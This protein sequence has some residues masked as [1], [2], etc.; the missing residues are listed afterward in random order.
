M[1]KDKIVWIT[2]ASAGIGREMALQFAAAGAHVVVSARRENRLQQVVKDIEA[3][4][5]QGLAIACDVT[6]EEAVKQA[7]EKVVHH[8]GRLD[9]TVANAGFSIL[10]PLEDLSMEDWQ[11]QFS[12]NVFGLCS[13]IRHSLPHLRKTRGRAVLMSSV[14]GLGSSP[15]AAAY[16]AS[17]AAVRAIGQTLS[18]E[19]HGSGVSC[20]TLCPGFI[21]SEIGQVDKKGIYHAGSKDPRP[22]NLMWPTDRAVWAMLKAIK[23]RKREVIITGHGKIFGFLGKHM[24]GLVHWATTQKLVPAIDKA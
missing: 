20:T 16:S 17:K 19:L 24:P 3:C 15:R 2:G 9:I 7:L 8:F 18:M 4:G 1:F 6:N 22:Q 10:G 12:V 5:Q 13:T 14:A 11:R 23:K 21:D